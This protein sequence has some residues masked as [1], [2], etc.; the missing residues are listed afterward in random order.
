VLEI[1]I[2]VNSNAPGHTVTNGGANIIITIVVALP[3]T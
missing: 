3:L 2:T 1:R